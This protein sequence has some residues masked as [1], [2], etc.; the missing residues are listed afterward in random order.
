[1]DA[2]A[3]ADAVLEPRMLGRGYCYKFYRIFRMVVVI[4]DE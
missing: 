2:D 1:M 4:G 3:D